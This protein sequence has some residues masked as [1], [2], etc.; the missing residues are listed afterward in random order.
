ML[1]GPKKRNGGVDDALTQG[2][3]VVGQPADPVAWQRDAWRRAAQSV[4]RTWS[5]WSAADG[6]RRSELYGRYRSALEAEELA[7]ARLERALSDHAHNAR[8]K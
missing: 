3:P 1:F 8:S 5:E 4:T 2:D 6:R 7:A